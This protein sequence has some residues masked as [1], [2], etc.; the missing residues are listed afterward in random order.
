[1]RCAFALLFVLGLAACGGRG[2]DGVL[3]VAYIG[4]PSD[5]FEEGLRIGSAAQL[6][7]AST[8]QGLVRLNAAGEVV[9]GLAERWIVTDDGESYIFRITE[10]DLPDG[11][12]LTA[13]TVRD[14]LARTIRRLDGTSLGLDLAK[15]AEVR[16]MTGR[17]VEIRL[18]SPMP[19][20]LQLLAQPELGITL[21]AARTGP[22]TATREGDTL[23]LSAM[24]PELRGQPSQADWGEGLRSIRFQTLDAESAARGFQQ[25]RFDLMLGGRVQDLPRASTSTFSRA[26]VRLD[27]AIGLFGLDVVRR[28]G[29]LAAPE[30]REALALAID[31]GAI[32]NALG[33]GGWASTTRIVPGGLPGVEPAAERWADLAPDQRQA[34][35]AQRVAAWR[36]ASGSAPRLVVALPAGPG[37]DILFDR[38]SADLAAVGIE[39]RRATAGTAADLV[40]RDRVAR[41]AGPRWFLNQ[42]NCRV[43]PRACLEDVDFLV[44]LAVD[45]ANPAEEA[46]YLLEAEQALLAAN[47]FVPLGAP[48]RWTQTRAE[49]EGFA[50]NAWAFHPLFP[51]TLAPI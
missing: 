27:S 13:N 1:M 16:A 17:V 8:Q 2:D 20:F 28:Q 3:D 47:V 18:K 21:E 31:R 19:G 12:R 25:N 22:M 46:S 44:S 41:F 14:S 7:R 10:F 39:L 37:S 40:L 42:F 51:L 6:V 49:V 4:Q 48:I 43:S 9:P 15:V 45:A 30:N 36:A 35:A 29:F 32:A 50:E 33:I 38:L 23:L 5:A 24:A 11:S 26:A 34:R